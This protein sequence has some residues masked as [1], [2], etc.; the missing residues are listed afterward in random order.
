M[1]EICEAS[2]QWLGILVVSPF[3]RLSQAVCWQQRRCVLPLAFCGAP[4]LDLEPNAVGYCMQEGQRML[5]P[6][7]T[8]D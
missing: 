1:I 3:T 8:Y 5:L 6:L 4:D 2:I 7:G